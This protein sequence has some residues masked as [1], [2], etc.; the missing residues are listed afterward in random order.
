MTLD[1]L[2]KQMKA[3]YGSCEKFGKDLGLCKSAVT[4]YFTG[5][6][7]PPVN[8]LCKMASLLKLDVIDVIEAFYA[9]D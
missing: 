4:R 1:E 7:R 8:R 5:D 9:D 6:R 3:Q 2:R